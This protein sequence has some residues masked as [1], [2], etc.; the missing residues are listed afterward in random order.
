M[1]CPS[2]RI[3]LGNA[4]LHTINISLLCRCLSCCVVSYRCS[5]DKILKVKQ[6]RTPSKRQTGNSVSTISSLSGV[7]LPF[8]WFFFVF[9]GFFLPRKKGFRVL[10]ASTLL[11]FTCVAL[12]FA[13]PTSSTLRFLLRSAQALEAPAF[14]QGCLQCRHASS[15]FLV[16]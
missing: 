3:T 10:L 13:Q 5:L 16:W 1:D 12:S 15:Q 9:F 11:G 8:F 7:I 4:S 14:S 2:R 6:S